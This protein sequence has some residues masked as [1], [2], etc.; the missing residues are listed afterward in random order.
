MLIDCSQVQFPACYLIPD[1]KV[2]EA[3]IGPTWALSAPD[4]PHVGPMNVAIKDAYLRYPATHFTSWHP[5]SCESEVHI[6]QLTNYLQTDL[7][8]CLAEVK[9]MYGTVCGMGLLGERI[10][11]NISMG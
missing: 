8:G 9:L 4:E 6:F 7:G 11:F 5:T 10:H 1:S 2:H 3:N